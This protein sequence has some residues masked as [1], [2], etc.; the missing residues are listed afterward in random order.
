MAKTPKL[1]LALISLYALENNGV[2]HLAAVA[3]HAGYR[4]IEIYFKDWSNNRFPWPTEKEVNHLIDLLGEHEVDLIGMSVRASAFHQMATH[5]TERLRTALDLPILWGGMHPT[6]C[7]EEAIQVA[8]YIAVGECELALVPFLKSFEA[9]NGAKNCPNFWQRQGDEILRNDM[10]PLPETLDELPFRDYHTQDDKYLVDGAKIENGDPFISNPEYTI[11]ASRGCIYWTCSFCSNAY[12]KPLYEG[13]GRY[14]RIRSPRSLIDEVIYAREM[15]QDMKVIRF[16]DEVFPMMREWIDEFCEIYPKEVGLPFEVLLDPR[17]IDDR[18]ISKLKK[19]GLRAAC[20]GVQHT[21]RVNNTL[22]D[23]PTTNAQVVH[24]GQVFKRQGLR[25]AYQVIFDDPVSTEA[26]KRA[27]FE[28]FMEVPRPFDIYLFGLTLY[29]NTPLV[30][31]LLSEGLI[32]EDDVEGKAT[33]AFSQFRVDLGYPRPPEDDFWL[34]LLVLV[35][36]DF[37]P[38][39]MLR[40]IMDNE[41]LRRD[42]SP[43]VA[44]AQAANIVKM[45]GVVLKL[46]QRR[47]MTWTLIK[48]WA[49]PNSLITA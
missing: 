11:L 29:P 47:E 35:S 16:D 40:Q 42:P 15:N 27:L 19:A 44:L 33:H 10:G 26:D 4:V 17:C 30:K 48:R 28:M 5:L 13:K 43:L 2:R 34:S 22:Y 20:M 21:E 39:A 14:V 7:P 38:R 46:I 1:K 3:R 31:R 36:K 24:A 12:T 18:T 41:A 37:I 32:T 23:R 9:G 8:D 49:N 6:F 45:G 25:I